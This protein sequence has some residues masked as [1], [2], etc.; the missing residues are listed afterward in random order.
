MKGLLVLQQ[1]QSVNG[2]ITG[3]NF[4]RPLAALVFASL[5][6]PQLFC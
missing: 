4:I 5:S 1:G 6:V 2:R 3:A